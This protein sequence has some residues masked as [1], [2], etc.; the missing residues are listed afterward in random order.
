MVGTETIRSVSASSGLYGL[1][2]SF[3]SWTLQHLAREAAGRCE[4]DHGLDALAAVVLSYA[5]LEAFLNEVSQLP[6]TLVRAGERN[7]ED[8]SLGEPALLD[9]LYLEMTAA[10]SSRASVED[11]YDVAWEFLAGESIDRGKGTRQRLQ[12]L[13]RLRND[14]VHAK[15]S[16]VE[17]REYID[18]ENPI[19]FGGVPMGFVEPHHK[20]PRYFR[21]L[22][23]WGLLAAGEKHEF[24]LH[25]I[26]SA[27]LARWAC[28]TVERLAED[29]LS[30]TPTS[31]VFRERLKL[32]TLAGFS[33]RRAP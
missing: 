32:Y 16:E 29:L 23:S 8:L 33:S 7:F 3:H 19:T 9:G 6:R 10:S 22:E 27:S 15:S 5:A 2:A 25:R 30:Q 31:S 17:L 24:W 26:C 21:A 28:D 14:L 1:N 13:T 11:R 18:L 12:V 20:P 4:G